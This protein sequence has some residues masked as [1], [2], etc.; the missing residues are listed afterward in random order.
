MDE[1]N[2]QDLSTQTLRK[3]GDRMAEDYR[4]LVRRLKRQKRLISLL[5][6]VLA[7]LS[8]TLLFLGLSSD[9]LQEIFILLAGVV[10][11]VLFYAAQTR[12]AFSAP[13]DPPDWP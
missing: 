1:Q 2:V 12:V 11:T 9:C 6:A 5:I 4:T 3:K 13:K 7:A 8:V 10:L